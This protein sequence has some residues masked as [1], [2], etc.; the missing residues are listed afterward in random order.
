MLEVK[1]PA[2]VHRHPMSST[3]LVTNFIRE[4][5]TKLNDLGNV[6][7]MPFIFWLFFFNG[8]CLHLYDK[9]GLLFPLTG[10][11][12]QFSAQVLLSPD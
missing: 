4:E 6:T 8:K 10:G 12:G 5:K 9:E 3:C 2:A 1:V 11:F 7:I